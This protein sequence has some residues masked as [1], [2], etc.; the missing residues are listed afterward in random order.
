MDEGSKILSL[1][2]IDRKDLDNIQ[3]RHAM[4][5][6]LHSHLKNYMLCMDRGYFGP[7]SAQE[8]ELTANLHETM[9]RVEAAMCRYYDME[10]AIL[11]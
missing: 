11:E 7:K 4:L 3:L 6:S 8:T 5:A 10:A 9:S 1:A 2:N